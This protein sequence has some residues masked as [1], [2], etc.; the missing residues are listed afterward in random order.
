MFGNV[1]GLKAAGMAKSSQGLTWI[2]W[3]AQLK[4]CN[5]GLE[6]SGIDG[7]RVSRF[8]VLVAEQ[9]LEGWWNLVPLN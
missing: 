5:F 2:K 9:G 7:F 6:S 1:V 8:A 3:R 4:A